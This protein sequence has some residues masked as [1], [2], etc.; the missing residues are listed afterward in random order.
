MRYPYRSML[1]ALAIATC[2]GMA[3]PGHVMAQFAPPF[4]G[5]GGGGSLDPAS[6]ITDTIYWGAGGINTDGTYCGSPAELTINSGPKQYSI[7]CLD[8]DG[9]TM[10]G[11][12]VMPDGWD[13]GTVT[14]ELDATQT[15]ADT[16]AMHSDISCSCRGE[17]DTI[18]STLGAE[19]AIDDAAVGGS[20]IQDAATSSAVTCNASCAAGDT[21]FWRWQLDAAGTTTA[22]STYNILGIKMEFTKT[23]G[24]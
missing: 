19:V 8:N 9:S 10:W 1:L 11:S 23:V 17:G 3:T 22:V 16:N 4:A 18:N 2:M 5:S 24:D 21:L 13:G 12:A 14:F 15:A 20:N 7:I 6:T